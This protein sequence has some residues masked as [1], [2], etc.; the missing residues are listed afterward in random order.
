MIESKG[1]TTI[2]RVIGIVLIIEGVLLFI[3]ADINGKNHIKHEVNYES[4]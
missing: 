2:M 3:G 4:Y 1:I